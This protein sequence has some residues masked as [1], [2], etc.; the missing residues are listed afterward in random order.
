MARTT[1]LGSI[2]FL[3]TFFGIRKA[4]KKWEFYE[5]N[6]KMLWVML[7]KL[8]VTLQKWPFLWGKINRCLREITLPLSK[9]WSTYCQGLHLAT[10][11]A[12]ERQ[13]YRTCFPHSC[14]WK[15]NSDLI[16]WCH[17]L[18]QVFPHMND[19]QCPT[20]GFRTPQFIAFYCPKAAVLRH[21]PPGL[22]NLLLLC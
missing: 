8:C 7:N 17:H 12:V 11:E 5:S 20:L 15:A 4:A 22:S 13:H 1:T 19:V 14:F 9:Q 18:Q 16:S 21:F 2:S 10:A 3:H 6:H